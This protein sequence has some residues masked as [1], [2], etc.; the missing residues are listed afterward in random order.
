MEPSLIHS[1]SQIR[2]VRSVYPFFPKRTRSLGS[3]FIEIMFRYYENQTAR[4]HLFLVYVRKC[5]LLSLILLIANFM[6]FS[7]FFFFIIAHEFSYEVIILF[8]PLFLLGERV[9]ILQDKLI[10][11]GLFAIV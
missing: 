10:E 3:L 4:E 6:A 7:F 9:L 11:I 1:F 2:H 8:I 5:A